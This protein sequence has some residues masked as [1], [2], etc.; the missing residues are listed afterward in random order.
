[1]LTVKQPN[2]KEHIGNTYINVYIYI[3]ARLIGL[4]RRIT[5]HKKTSNQTQNTTCT[6]MWNCWMTEKQLSR[7]VLSLWRTRAYSTSN[8]WMLRHL[9]VS[10][11]HIWCCFHLIRWFER[12][13]MQPNPRAGIASRYKGREMF[14]FEPSHSS[15]LIKTAFAIQH[16]HRS[17]LCPTNCFILFVWFGVCVCLS[18]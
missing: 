6:D 5:R 8:L 11:H 10:W 17:D 15:L 7:F 3:S 16:F 14:K 4:R 2:P 9:V 13:L 18:R 12:R 1:M